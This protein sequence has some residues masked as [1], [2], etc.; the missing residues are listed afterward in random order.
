MFGFFETYPKAVL[1]DQFDDIQ[2]AAITEHIGG[3]KPIYDL[4]VEYMVLGL[5]S[6]ERFTHR[7]FVWYK[8]RLLASISGIAFEEEKPYV[9]TKHAV[10]Q[11]AAKASKIADGII[12][13]VKSIDTAVVKQNLKSFWNKITGKAPAA[14]AQP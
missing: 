1:T 14:E 13:D 12:A 7:S 11:N 8:K 6:Y 9:D 4:F 5:P 3:N 10:D 2:L